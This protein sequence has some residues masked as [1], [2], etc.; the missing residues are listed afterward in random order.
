MLWGSPSSPWRG[1]RRRELGPQPAGLAGLP[2]NR[3]PASICQPWGWAVLEVTSPTLQTGV[4]LP[5]LMLRGAEMSHPLW[6]LLKLQIHE[7][8]NHFC[9]FKTITLGGGETIVTYTLIPLVYTLEQPT[10]GKVWV[11]KTDTC[12]SPCQKGRR[13]NWDTL[14]RI[15]DRLTLPS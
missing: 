4:K 1:P 12:S 8:V 14:F 13:K 2:A 5:Q 3:L 15:I 11:C 9:Y 7:Q 10:R 6:T